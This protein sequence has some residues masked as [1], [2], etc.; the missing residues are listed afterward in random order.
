[1]AISQLSQ[2]CI[3]I[4]KIIQY[5]RTQQK[6]KIFNFVDI[7]FLRGN[8]KLHTLHRF[9]HLRDKLLQTHAQ[10]HLTMSNMLTIN[11]GG[12]SFIFDFFHHAFDF[13]PIK[14]SSSHTSIRIHESRKFI[15]S[16]KILSDWCG[17]CVL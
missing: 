2:Y 12:K 10:I 15:N 13:H 9:N 11:S 5:K 1:M 6:D 8:K 4:K 16:Q 17:C 7:D 3:A 14:T